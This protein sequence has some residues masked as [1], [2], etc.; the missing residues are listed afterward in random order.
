MEAAKVDPVTE[1]RPPLP[2]VHEPTY[3]FH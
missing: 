1:Y 3:Q 2:M